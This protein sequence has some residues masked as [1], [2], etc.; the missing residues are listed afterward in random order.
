MTWKELYKPTIGKLIVPAAI[1]IWQIYFL[2]SRWGS[3]FM[4]EVDCGTNIT[5]ALT[6]LLMSIVLIILIVYPIVCWLYA[7]VKWIIK[8][9][10]K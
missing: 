7:L 5:Y 3:F 6:S 1:F 4:C 9:V 10:K 2:I 8:R